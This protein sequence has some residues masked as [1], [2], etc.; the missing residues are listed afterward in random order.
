MKKI[1]SILSVFAILFSTHIFAQ[2]QATVEKT[3]PPTKVK[4]YDIAD[5][6]ASPETD[7]QELTNQLNKQLSFTYQQEANVYQINLETAQKRLALNSLQANNTDAFVNQVMNLYQTR[8]TAIENVLTAKQKLQFKELKESM[9]S[10]RID[11]E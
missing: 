1:L 8:N 5:F 3:T 2:D 11:A 9:M 6:Y 10:K 7:A 4:V